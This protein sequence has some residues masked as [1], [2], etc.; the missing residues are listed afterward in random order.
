MIDFFL[1]KMR[2]TPA[3][4]ALV[5]FQFSATYQGLLESFEKFS[6]W[7]KEKNILPGAV[8]SFDGDYSP[9]SIA[10]FL[11]LI[12]NN[13]I[14]VP[15][16]LDS[17]NHFSEFRDIASTEYDISLENGQPV[18]SKTQR[19]ADHSIYQKLREQQHPG[20]VLFSSGSTGKSKAIVQD[21]NKLMGK[22]TTPRKS[23]RMLIFLQLDH[24][25][26]INSLLY[27]LANN[28]MI[29]VS[30]DRSSAGVCRAV[31]AFKA[32]LLP[33]SPTF[34]NLLMLSK[35]YQDY[36]LSSLKL[37][38]Y[39]TEPM[40]ES[41]LKRLT[42]ILPG[43]ILQQTYGL[44]EVGILRSKSRS[45]DSL[46]L[47][48]G[49]EEFTTKIVND[50]LWIKSDSA[51]LGYLNAPNPFDEEGF[52]DTGDLVEQDGDWIRILGRASEI[53]N[54]GGYKVFPAEV[55]SVLL[56]ME[57]VEDV[58]VFGQD[59]MLTGK[60]VVAKIK[61]LTPETL[62][63]LKAR[64]LVFCRSKLQSYKVPG[65]I[66]IT[67]ETIYNERFKRMRRIKKELD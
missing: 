5:S 7:I 21:L 10:L 27:S 8:V 55:E 26:G 22:F 43:T 28:G 66:I 49:G 54:V 16:S 31:E 6:L 2:D 9:L 35:V 19:I 1:Q 23:L 29:I 59:H 57:N 46:W 53:I 62:R 42:S 4:Q 11:S 18:L 60:I 48:V 67:D 40:Q 37:I 51:M 20:L 12:K 14:I 24:I 65:K 61:L 36:D 50:T 63:E 58:V 32:E 13:N 33:T 47:K 30:D 17:K 45:S 52:L 39:G 25:G 38:T 15:L 64:M 56:E 41:T 44:S 3:H 34:L